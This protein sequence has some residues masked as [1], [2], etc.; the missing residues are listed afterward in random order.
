MSRRLYTGPVNRSFS[1]LKFPLEPRKSERIEALETRLERR[2]LAPVVGLLRLA[3][4]NLLLTIVHAVS[5]SLRNLGRK[6]STAAS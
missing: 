6:T 2:E 4:E 3:G 5:S 1:K